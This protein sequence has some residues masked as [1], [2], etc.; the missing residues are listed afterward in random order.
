MKIKRNDPEFAIQKGLYEAFLYLV[1]NS[2]PKF[3]NKF[4]CGPFDIV[5]RWSEKKSKLY[6]TLKSVNDENL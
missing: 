1:Q 4:G 2:D 6:I 5:L 3:I